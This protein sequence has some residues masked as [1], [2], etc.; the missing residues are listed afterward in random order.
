ML[1]YYCKSNRY[2][3]IPNIG[4]SNTNVEILIVLALSFVINMIQTLA[5]L[6]GTRGM[7]IMI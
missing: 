5:A 4:C 1:V 7:S 3:Q 2:I 6:S